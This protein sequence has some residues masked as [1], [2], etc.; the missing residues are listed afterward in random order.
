MQYY[1]IRLLAAFFVMGSFGLGFMAGAEYSKL[2]E[3]LTFI[4]MVSLG[5]F[6]H[7]MADKFQKQRKK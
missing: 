2:A 3:W 4:V 7:F 5:L 6:F 1:T